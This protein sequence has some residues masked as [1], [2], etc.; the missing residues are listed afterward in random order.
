MQKRQDRARPN[1]VRG[2]KELLCEGAKAA[3]ILYMNGE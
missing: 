1:K 2:G 3:E